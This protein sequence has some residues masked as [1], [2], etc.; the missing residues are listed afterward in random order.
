[1]QTT[2]DAVYNTGTR[3]RHTEPEAESENMNGVKTLKA[4]KVCASAKVRCE[5]EK[6]DRKCRRYLHP[7][8][9]ET[10]FVYKTAPSK[11][12]FGSRKNVLS[13]SGEVI[14]AWD[15]Q[16]QGVYHDPQIMYM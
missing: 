4:C 2:T 3:G 1:M 16:Q 12:A 10:D 15:A 9:F 8:L 5:I 7:D 6:G 14:A 13:S 11:D